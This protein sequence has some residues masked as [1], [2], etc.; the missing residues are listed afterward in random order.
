MG[1]YVAR[2]ILY[3][4]YMNISHR[5]FLDR[6]HYIFEIIIIECLRVSGDDQ[7]K[8]VKVKI[9]SKINWPWKV[10]NSLETASRNQYFCMYAPI[11]IYI[12]IWVYVCAYIQKLIFVYIYIYIYTETLKTSLGRQKCR[13]VF[14]YFRLVR[15]PCNQVTCSNDINKYALMCAWLSEIEN[16]GNLSVNVVHSYLRYRVSVKSAFAYKH[17]NENWHARS[18][19]FVGLFT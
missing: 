19:F 10:G 13:C 4:L 9:E 2:I 8:K 16:Y 11:Y 6:Q 18:R 7:N 5:H 3:V 14:L 1:Q 12:Y 17:K 15:Q